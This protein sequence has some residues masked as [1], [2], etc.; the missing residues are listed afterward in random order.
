MREAKRASAKEV[1]VV[2]GHGTGQDYSFNSLIKD[3]LESDSDYAS[4]HTGDAMLSLKNQTAMPCYCP[5][6]MP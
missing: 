4:D 6:L 1:I 2:V 5:G 3:R